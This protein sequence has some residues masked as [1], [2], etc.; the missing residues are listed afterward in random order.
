MKKIDF[1]TLKAVFV[2]CTLKKSPSKSHTRNLMDV[3]VKIMKSEGVDVEILRH[4][5]AYYDEMLYLKVGWIDGLQDL[6]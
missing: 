5:W 6:F 2:N 1:S 4:W 3:S